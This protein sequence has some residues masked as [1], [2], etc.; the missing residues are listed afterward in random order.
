MEKY[1]E[2]IS[3][4]TMRPALIWG[5]VDGSFRGFYRSEDNQQMHYSEHKD[6]H[7]YHFQGVVT[8]DGM[9]SSLFGP[10]WGR[11]NDWQ[12][13]EISGVQNQI[14]SIFQQEPGRKKLYL[15]GDDPAYNDGY[16]IFCPYTEATGPRHKFNKDMSS[17]RIAVEN[18]FG[19]TRNLWTAHA[20]NK[21]MKLG[22]QPV[23]AYY[24]V[25]VLLT[26][27]YTCIRG[28][29]TSGR[30]MMRPPTLHQY[31]TGEIIT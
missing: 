7:G 5:F 23:A 6:Y 28:N 10:D 4:H 3:D 30:F 26:N 29:Q 27:C 12:L 13:F 19:I 24:M 25:A 18:S 20:F 1:A 16:G 17:A 31:L 11:V 2:V 21:H 15:Y 22:L 9:V 8:P 14:R